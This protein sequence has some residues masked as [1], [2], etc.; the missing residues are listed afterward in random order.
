MTK[1][2]SLY[3]TVIDLLKE[4]RTPETVARLMQLPVSLVREFARDMEEYAD[5]FEGNLQ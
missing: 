3:S 5:E 4:G 2:K 1:L